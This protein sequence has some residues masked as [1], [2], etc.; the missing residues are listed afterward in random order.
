LLQFG[1]HKSGTDLCFVYSVNLGSV[2]AN[3]ARQYL[4][5]ILKSSFLSSSLIFQP[6]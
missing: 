4:H 6:L 3:C 2:G 5:L 1:Q